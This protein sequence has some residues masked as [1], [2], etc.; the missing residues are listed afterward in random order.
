MTASLRAEYEAL[1]EATSG[2]AAVMQDLA[3]SCPEHGAIT[4]DSE[5][6]ACAPVFE[7]LQAYNKA[8]QRLHYVQHRYQL[9]QL[10]E[11]VRESAEQVVPERAPLW[12]RLLHRKAVGS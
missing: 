6:V 10:L 7:A 2:A 8:S 9:E 11:R 1:I 12:R 4:I 3:G 5:C